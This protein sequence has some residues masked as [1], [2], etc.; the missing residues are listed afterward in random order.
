MFG[1]HVAQTV[2][3]GIISTQ[4]VDPQ[5]IFA[6]LIGAIVWNVITW[7][8]GIPSSS[9]HALIG[10][11][12]GAGLAKA[13]FSVVVWSG[14]LKTVVGIFASPAVG[15]VLALV[16]VLLVAW[17]SLKLTPL[18]V[19]KRFRKL[20]LISAAAYS[21]GHGGN[22]AQKTMGI[23]TVLLFS[24]GVYQGRIPCALLGRHRLPGGD[25]VRHHVG[26]VEDRAHHGLEDHPA[27]ARPGLLRGDRRRDHPVHGDVRRRA[28]LL[29]AHHHRRDRRCGRGTA[30][31]GSALERRQ[32]H[33]DRVVRHSARRSAGR[34]A[35]LVIT[36]LFL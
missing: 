1:Q 33:R 2:G 16:L 32:Q 34:R 5:V 25:G 10:G 17:S 24:Q 19:D 36:G 11:L 21:L 7:M 27:D 28:R 14:V 30:L 29:D 31:F 35:D 20:Q 12:L 22:D 9:S 3:T 4:I 26:R 18:G 6:A 13:G 8:L 15:L 23:I